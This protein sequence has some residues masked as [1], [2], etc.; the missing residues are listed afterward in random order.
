MPQA[1]KCISDPHRRNSRLRIPRKSN[2][3]S[4]ALRLVG[5]V[6]SRCFGCCGPC[7]CGNYSVTRIFG[8]F[9]GD[10]VHI[11]AWAPIAD[12]IKPHEV[13]QSNS[14]VPG[15]VRL[16]SIQRTNKFQIATCSRSRLALAKTHHV[17]LQSGSNG[18]HPLQVR[19]NH[20]MSASPFLK[21]FLVIRMRPHILTYTHC[22][23]C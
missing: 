2:S 11:C 8:S 1:L 10:A 17:S 15:L 14:A 12:P 23:G 9:L 13:R 4:T 16:Q 20:T 3:R 18:R 21:I 7:S 6:S 19:C 5:V 22:D